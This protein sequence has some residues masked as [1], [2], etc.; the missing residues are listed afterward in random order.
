MIDWK[1]YPKLFSFHWALKIQCK[2]KM[3]FLHHFMTFSFC[4]LGL[5]IPHSVTS[6]EEQHRTPSLPALLQTL[7]ERITPL[8]GTPYLHASA[9]RRSPRPPNGLGMKT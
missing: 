4:L 5:G 1:L 3:M 7:P 9:Y 6:T 2:N 8:R